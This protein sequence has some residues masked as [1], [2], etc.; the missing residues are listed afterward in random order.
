MTNSE[1]YRRSG[2]ARLANTASL[3]ILFVTAIMAQAQTYRV[4]HSFGW[5]EGS[6]PVAGLTIG[7]G[8]NLYGTALEGGDD[9]GYICQLYS[10]TAGC[11]T[12]FKLWNHQ[13]DWMFS[14]LFKFNGSDGA[15]PATSV[16]FGPNGS[17]YGETG[18]GG[19]CTYSSYGCGTIFNLTPGATAPPAVLGLWSESV[20]YAFTGN[21]DGGPYP[22]AVIFDNAGNLYGTTD[23]GT[24]NAGNVFEFTPLGGH[25]SETVLYSFYGGSDGQYP[26]GVLA[27]AGFNHLFGITFKGGND[28]CGSAGCGTIFEL[29]RGESG[30][31]KTTLH[32]FADG[33]DGAWPEFTPIMDAAGNLY[34][35]TGGY[36]NPGTVWEM[37]PSNGGW[38]FTVLYTFSTPAAGPFSGLAMDA[39]G[40][41]YG[42]T[43]QG[44]LYNDGSVFELSPSNGGG[45]TYTD[46][47]NFTG[48]TD[49]GWPEGDVA[50]DGNGNIYGITTGGGSSSKG[51]VWEITR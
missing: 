3:L 11:G 41:L 12:V 20:P 1:K 38:T 19:S 44:G 39:A 34:G 9:N 42:T 21:D 25:W 8:G 43:Y 40:N 51:V 47:Y 48:G 30:W 45:W 26:K 15:Y 32:T 5:Y 49:G 17:L 37:S 35:T 2:I 36:N 14:L 27:D 46:L 31:T 10:D 18:L 50:L 22:S 4:I 24:Y 7:P 13:G 28:G 16:T 29:T 23:Y 33:G 6:T